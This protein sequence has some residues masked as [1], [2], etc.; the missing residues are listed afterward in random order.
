MG[1]GLG[2]RGAPEVPKPRQGTWCGKGS[3]DWAQDGCQGA[4]RDEDRS[5]EGAVRMVRRSLRQKLQ[6]FAG[7]CGWEERLRVRGGGQAREGQEDSKI[8][9]EGLLGEVGPRNKVDREG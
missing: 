9:G 7:L 2:G 5:R 4:R 1:E 8:S 3:R 6:K